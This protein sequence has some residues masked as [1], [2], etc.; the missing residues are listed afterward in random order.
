MDMSRRFV[1]LPLGSTRGSL[2]L[3][4]GV[5]LAQIFNDEVFAPATASEIL[6]RRREPPIF[7]PAIDARDVDAI[8]IRD[9]LDCPQSDI[10][11]V[12]VFDG[13]SPEAL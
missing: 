9:V 10:V 1:P 7:L 13:H 12:T 4:A 8:V 2:F 6:F 3:A 11:G 5:H